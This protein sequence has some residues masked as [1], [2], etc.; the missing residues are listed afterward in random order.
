M[1]TESTAE[2]S[3]TPHDFPGFCQLRPAAIPNSL[4]RANTISDKDPAGRELAT[5]CVKKLA[6]D[7]QL[8]LF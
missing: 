6:M 3:L 5:E 1:G 2:L 8:S 4:L 7:V